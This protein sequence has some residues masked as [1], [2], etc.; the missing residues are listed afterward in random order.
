MEIALANNS[1]AAMKETL[2][3]YVSEFTG[4]GGVKVKFNGWLLEIS[5][6]YGKLLTYDLK[7]HKEVFGKIK[8][9]G[10]AFQDMQVIGRAIGRL[11]SQLKNIYMKRK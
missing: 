4:F 2:G 1:V 11:I 6:G 7:H 3:G 5:C 10:L 8:T 9:L